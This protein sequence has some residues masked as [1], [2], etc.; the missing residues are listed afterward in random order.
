MK[1]VRSMILAAALTLT[2]ASAALATPS[3]Q[4]WIPSPDV[5]GFKEVNFG[6]DYYGRF[7]SKADAGP[8]YY[9]AGV[10][11]GVSPFENLKLEIG[12]DYLTT[13][14]QNDNAYDAH[15]IYF[16]AKMGTPE[17]AFGIKGMPAFAVGIYNM[18]TFDKPEFAV[19]T[20]QNIVYGLVGK[21]LPVIGRLSAGGYYGAKR[22]LATGFNPDNNNVGMLASWDRSMTEISDKLWLA[23]DYMSGNNA[24]GA[25]SVGG[26]WAFS[27][28]V[29]LL[30]GT[31]FF[32]PFYKPS[33]AGD[34]PGGK[35]AFTTQ[36]DINF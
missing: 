32:N 12:V 17:D 8:N 11:V 29:S 16:N 19:S 4:V 21:T 30:V 9:D 33:G 5:K 24:N 36:L 10:T 31:V 35:P 6:I 7:S 13:S 22:A 18:G 14:L 28:N 3:T 27:K 34:L 20:R 26:S 2:C 23:V 15:P 1:S 25:L